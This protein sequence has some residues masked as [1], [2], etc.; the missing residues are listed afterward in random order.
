MQAQA[1][2][3]L[4]LGA[5]LAGGLSESP[6]IL[7]A[8]AALALF[9]AWAADQAGYPL[10]HWAPGALIVL[11]LLAI[12]LVN[13]PLEIAEISRPVRVAVGCLA[14][15]T[16]LSYFSI[17][18]ASAPAAAWEGA[19]RTLLYL[20]AFALFALWCRRARSAA[21]LLGAWTAALI[22]LALFVV[23]HL[24]AAGATLRAL[25]PDGR[26][27]YPSGYANAN[28]A[29]WLMAFWPALFLARSEALHWALRGLFG[30]GAV[31]L[32]DLALLSQ[33]RG[34][35]YASAVML[36]VVFALIGERLR[37][38]AVLV[39]VAA[40]IGLSAPSLLRVGDHL[41]AG[42]V[43]SSN[44]HAG[45][46]AMLLAGLVVGLLLALAAKIESQRQFSEAV[47][48]RARRVL[49]LLATVTLLAA[50]AGGLAI[51]GNP[52]T[53]VEHAWNT[54]KGGYG[55]DNSQGSRLVSGLGSNRYDFYRVALDEFIEHP[56]VGI[57]ADN[58]FQQYLRHR[59]SDET[60]RY[61]HSVELR[62][63]SE[64]GLLGALLGLAGLT[65]ALLAGARSLRSEDRLTRAVAGGAL[66][67]FSYWLIHGSV[68]WF[69]EFA[70]LG[71]PAFALLGIACGLAPAPARGWSF[72]RGW[73]PPRRLKIAVAALVCVAGAVSLAAP[74]FSQMQIQQAARVWVASPQRAYALLGGAAR[75]DPLS[76]EPY[77]IAG[78]IAAR[79]GDLT[80]ADHEFSL[81][82]GRSPENV[83]ATLERGAIAST[84]GQRARALAL[85]ARAAALDP[86]D[87]LIQAALR[88]ARHG[89]LVGVKELNRAILLGARE[90]A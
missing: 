30:G 9:V 50:V 47:I 25:L 56:L 83:Y 74:W 54:F 52:I 46:R 31:V 72:R 67:G 38:F 20:L 1:P 17:L 36:I 27:S 7:P 61:P 43:V 49:S 26:L 4:R 48:L 78:G 58:F 75:L 19:D 11:A 34:S 57:G 65:A 24:D 77:L 88:L 18:W 73:A 64:T 3:R 53:R 71:A 69:W 15:Y 90:L 45:L 32:A 82:L 29:Q 87:P 6:I 14:C 10:T 76:E 89:Q 5:L 80:L 42:A 59:R 8:L 55:A 81:A 33:S 85:L 28:A 68:D 16:A 63:L 70:G 39:P 60:P 44:L 21:L 13:I 23:V 51:A 41:R 2:S 35:V 40:G 84:L 79:L 62:T 86:R 37:T 22:A 66:A 12:A